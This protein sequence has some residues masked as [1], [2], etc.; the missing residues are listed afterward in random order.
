[1][2]GGAGTGKE[3]ALGKSR[4]KVRMPNG[5]HVP[6][7]SFLDESF[8]VYDCVRIREHLSATITPVKYEIIGRANERWQP[9][10]QSL[11]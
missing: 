3:Y 11:K 4:Y 10:R 1:M 2:Y 7:R 6:A 8:V 5:D 9:K